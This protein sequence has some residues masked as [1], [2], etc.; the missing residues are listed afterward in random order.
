[1]SR[2]RDII[3]IVVVIGAL[4]SAPL[5][6]ADAYSPHTTHRHLSEQAVEVFN[7]AYSDISLSEQEKQWVAA[8]ADEE[9]S[10]VARV[11]RHFYDP[12]YDRGLAGYAPSTDWVHSAGMQQGIG[13]VYTWEEALAAYE[14]GDKEYAYRALGHILHLI[15][16][17]TVP[18]HTRQDPHPPFWEAVW[19]GVDPYEYGT[20]HSRF[21]DIGGLQ[22]AYGSAINAYITDAAYYTNTH[23]LS[24][25]SAGAYA[26]PVP[27]KIEGG[28]IY[29]ID[30]SDEY[31]IA[32][33]R[34][35]DSRLIDIT[36]RLDFKN[37]LVLQDYWNRLAPQAIQNGAGAIK[38][39]K[40]SVREP[41]PPKTSGFWGRMASGIVNIG[42]T[43]G[44]VAEQ[45]YQATTS[46]GHFAGETLSF[47]YAYLQPQ[48]DASVSTQPWFSASLPWIGSVTIAGPTLDVDIARQAT[49]QQ[50]AGLDQFSQQLAQLAGQQE[51]PVPEEP[52]LSAAPQST[53]STQQPATSQEQTTPPQDGGV[54]GLPAQSRIVK[55]IDG[56]TVELETGERVRYIG[57]DAPEL[58]DAADERTVC[59]AE[60]AAQRNSD[61]VLHKIVRLESGPDNTDVYGRL[62]R[63]V[64]ADDV[65]V[66]ENLIAQG[67]AYAHDFGF[68][69]QYSDQFKQ[70]EQEAKQN[71]AGLWGDLCSTAAEEELPLEEDIPQEQD[72]Q[73]EIKQPLPALYEVVISEVEMDAREFVELYNPTQD[74]AP[75]AGY[76]FAYY[77]STRDAWN[78]PSRVTAFPNDAR[79]PANG[80]Y[81]IGFDDA[82]FDIYEEDWHPYNSAT[83]ANSKGTVAIF[84]ADPRE[85]ESVLIDAVGWGDAQL[86]ELE[87][88]AEPLEENESA[89]RIF[90]HSDIDNNNNAFDFSYTTTPTPRW[91]N[92]ITIRRPIV[93]GGAANEPARVVISEVQIN[94]SEFVEF[95]NPTETLQ[96]LA[97]HYLAYYSSTRTTWNDAVSSKQ[98]PDSATMQPGAYFVIGLDDFAGVAEWSPESFSGLS[99]SSGTVALFPFDPKA[100]SANDAQAGIIDAVGW[101]DAQLSEAQPAERPG[102]G[103]STS[104]NTDNI[105]TNN[106]ALDFVILTEPTPGS[107]LGE[108][109]DRGEQ[110]PPDHLV[111]NEVHVAD[112]EFVELYNPTNDEISLG[113]YYF[114]YYSSS[115]VSWDDPYRIQIVPEDALVPAG[116][117]YLIGLKGFVTSNANPNA[118]WQPYTSAQLS[119]NAGTVAVFEN[120]PRTGGI[121]PLDVAAWGAISSELKEGEA[122]DSPPAGKSI[123]RNAVHSDSG[124]NNADFSIGEPTPHNSA[125]E[126]ASDTFSAVPVWGQQYA[127][128]QHTGRT[129]YRG[130]AQQPSVIF[131]S[132]V[133]SPV[134]SAL[135]QPVVDSDGTVYINADGRIRAFS[136]DGV[137]RW[138]AD[139]LGALALSPDSSRLYVAGCVHRDGCYFTTI[140]TQ[141]G[142]TRTKTFISS[143]ANNGGPTPPLVDEESGLVYVATTRNIF[144]FDQ[145]GAELWK[146]SWEGLDWEEILGRPASSSSV[147]RITMPVVRGGELFIIAQTTS[148]PIRWYLIAFNVES[149]SVLWQE[150][151][152]KSSG[153]PSIGSDGLLYSA[154][155][156]FSTSTDYYGIAA[157]DL[158]DGSRV[159]EARNIG[160]NNQGI[161]QVPAQYDGALFLVRF[162]GGL[163]HIV[164]P[165]ADPEVITLS[166][167]AALGV[168]TTI[169][170]A[171]VVDEDG[172]LYLGTEDGTIYAL[173]PSVDGVSVRWSVP[174]GARVL[175][176]AVGEG[177]IYALTAELRL[178]VLQ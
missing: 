135:S 96:Q 102:A 37:P 122:A 33:I 116:G 19:D 35:A 66:N 151:I 147:I 155:I 109:E 6:Y 140:D 16:D 49:H 79:I 166:V 165:N 148:T 139:A 23:F 45:A 48:V 104:R 12:I 168:D 60:A 4:F 32:R 173:V 111:I 21:G 138:Q 56:D 61:L 130:P 40:D 9:D 84:A 59:L 91:S 133:F 73:N 46:W 128:A 131:Q 107:G 7:R 108:D 67:Y 137:E 99:N 154:F 76:Y 72:G 54:G 162:D 129:S 146:T 142:A 157:Y 170:T 18:A 68:T 63:Y 113:G 134:Q 82:T 125:G 17:A 8:G 51:V 141:G 38:L 161:A 136:H 100:Q 89:A 65:F 145:D 81:L 127:N 71:K 55:I 26:D 110:T 53:Q 97:G 64:W 43:A 93:A 118:D 169:T 115:R 69:H 47:G 144:A 1:M 117:Y 143:V 28:Y 58:F 90:T 70:V 13:G 178:Y 57:I 86:A 121:V 11:L 74:D 174:L 106:N 29:T 158:A 85:E 2:R 44:G 149:G 77:P 101:G 14:R 92:E 103:E 41:E 50:Q 94:G 153:S 160:R 126:T 52:A 172:V 175:E 3:S 78:D 42:K 152:S 80:F 36:T 167:E 177:S 112:N 10:P 30:G 159:W 132:S 34:G 87:P 105:D 25:D 62:L 39:F 5:L 120:D 20:E 171:L 150:P 98:L 22:P 124:N 176:I 163:L 24:K 75:L 95:Y 88:F 114:V 119:N 123:T 27:S 83:L 31:R 156:Q 15:Q 164:Y